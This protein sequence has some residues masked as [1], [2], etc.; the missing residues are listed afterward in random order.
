M[1][2]FERGVGDRT[3]ANTNGADGWFIV[4]TDND[5]TLPREKIAFDTPVIKWIVFSVSGM[6][7]DEIWVIGNTVGWI[8]GGE[9]NPRGSPCGN[10]RTLHPTGRTVKGHAENYEA[11]KKEGSPRCGSVEKR[12]RWIAERTKCN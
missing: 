9:L 12:H 7:S 11:E 8:G 2:S 5:I 4:I 10:G 6:F 1:F 3:V